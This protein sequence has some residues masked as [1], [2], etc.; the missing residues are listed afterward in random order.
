MWK[1]D[2]FKLFYW[3]WFLYVYKERHNRFSFHFFQVLIRKIMCTAAFQTFNFYIDRLHRIRYCG[4]TVLFIFSD[5]HRMSR[6]QRSTNVV[7]MS[8]SIFLFYWDSHFFCWWSQ[9]NCKKKY[10]AY[11]F[12]FRRK[13]LKKRSSKNRYPRSPPANND[14]NPY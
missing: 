10:M 8:I 7:D 13:G 1:Y 14:N 4:H 9:N 6:R 3:T 11:F 2:L 5:F 12:F